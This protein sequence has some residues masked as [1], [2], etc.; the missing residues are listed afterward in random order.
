METCTRRSGNGPKKGNLCDLR[1]NRLNKFNFPGE[2]AAWI[3]NERSIR[4]LFLLFHASVC[5]CITLRSF[6]TVAR[7][8]ANESV[9]INVIPSD[10]LPLC[11]PYLNLSLRSPI[12]RWE[13]TQFFSRLYHKKIQRK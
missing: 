2:T 9:I 10:I 12:L 4:G 8:H 11:Q 6:R 13:K 7:T 3:T 5:R 1:R